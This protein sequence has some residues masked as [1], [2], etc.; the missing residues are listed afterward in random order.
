MTSFDFHA[1]LTSTILGIIVLGAAGSVVGAILIWVVSK[2]IKW[3]VKEVALDHAI[4]VIFP[5]VKY[6]KRSEDLK[7]YLSRSGNGEYYRL[8]LYERMM[9][10]YLSVAI[11]F[12]LFILSNLCFMLFWP[13]RPW[14]VAFMI[15]A[16]LYSFHSTLQS[17]LAYYILQPDELREKKKE[18]GSRY[19]TFKELEK[20]MDEDAKRKAREEIAR[21]AKNEG[22]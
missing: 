8:C 6:I 2:A 18:I 15:A 4:R 12:V 16:T 11:F 14:P 21:Q 19:K 22:Q 9:D 13:E 7:E 20:V 10:T 1:F 17:G 5:Y 3:Y